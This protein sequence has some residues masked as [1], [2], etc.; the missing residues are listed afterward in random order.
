MLDEYTIKFDV[1]IPEELF[2]ELYLN[3]K[4]TDQYLNNDN[5]IKL[6]TILYKVMEIYWNNLDKNKIEEILSFKNNLK[7][8]APKIA[9]V[10]SS[11]EATIQL[12]SRCYKLIEKYEQPY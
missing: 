1:N 4:K 11:D 3:Y 12:I 6:K 2:E 5:I 9:I 8:F 7:L 10:P